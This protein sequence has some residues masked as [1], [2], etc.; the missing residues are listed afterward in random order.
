MSGGSTKAVYVA[1]TANALVMVAKF[2]AFA[3]TGSAAMLSEGIHSF[4]DVGNQALLALGIKRSERAPTEEHPYGYTR[5]RFIWALISAVGIFFL[6]CGVTVYHGVSSLLHPHEA[7]SAD[8]LPVL[9]G[10]SI[11]AL[12][13]EG[14][15]LLVATRAIQAEAGDIPLIKHLRESSDPMAAAVLLEDG[16][17]VIGVIIASI[18]IGLTVVTHNPMWDAIAS[19]VIGLMLGVIAIVL[20]NRN[21]ELLLGESPSKE[22]VERVRAVLDAQ[23]EVDGVSDIKA[24]VLGSGR[25]RFKAEVDFDG[26]E[27]ARQRLE[28]MDLDATLASLTDTAAL[29]RFLVVFGDEMVESVGDAVDRIEARAAAAVPELAHVDLEAD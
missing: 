23:P 11:F 20:V 28:S 3:V 25:L 10:V 6:G 21:R 8:H 9:I 1:I 14:G 18:G 26:Q 24:V 22:V 29:E 17:A 16:A 15:S 13:L 19:I 2:G 27:L 12:V 7:F 5:A 4:A